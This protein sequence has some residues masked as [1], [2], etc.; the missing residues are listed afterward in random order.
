[1]AD[2][3]ICS[4]DGCGNTAKVR[5]WCYKHYN[6][7]NRHGDPLKSINRFR[8]STDPAPVSLLCT[9][10]GITKDLSA[11]S[12]SVRSDLGVRGCCKDCCRLSAVDYRERNRKRLNERNREYNRRNRTQS[13]ERNR[14]WRET[15][16]DKVRAITARSNAKIGN[17]PKNRIAKSLRACISQSINK[18]TKAARRTEALL[19]YSFDDL[20]VHLER[21]FAKGMS[22]EDYGRHGWHIDHILPISSFSYETPDDPEFRECWALTNLRPLWGTENISKGARRLLLI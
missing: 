19:G 13:L 11:Y 10:C 7:W 17:D 18:G 15:N 20:K 4:V 6:R 1:M 2:N 8:G 9:S 12:A 5:G 14:R 16:P 3:P 22:W 21:Q